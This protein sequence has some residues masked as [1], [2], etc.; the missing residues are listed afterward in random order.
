MKYTEL[1]RSRCLIIMCLTAHI[2]LAGCSAKFDNTRIDSLNIEA[3]RYNERGLLYSRD[4]NPDEAIKAFSLSISLSPS[5][6]AL[7]NRCVEYIRKGMYDLAESD[8]SRAIFL[9]PSYALSYFNRGN[10]YFKKNDY[11][12]AVGNYLKAIDLEPG[13]AEYFFNCGLA[14]NKLGQDEKSVDMYQKAVEINSKYYP[15][16]YNL[17]CIYS[18]KNDENKALTYLENAVN[19]GFSDADRMRKEPGLAAI[20]SSDRFRFLLQKLEKKRTGLQ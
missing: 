7:N 1:N 10:A 2:A 3:R 4:N 12:S 6:A 19:T 13:Q 8:A 20:R 16:S 14:Y 5:A 11:A 15:A 17:A 9:N 18:M